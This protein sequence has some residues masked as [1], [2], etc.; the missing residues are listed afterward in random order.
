VVG[1]TSLLPESAL[2][3]VAERRQPLDRDPIL[4]AVGGALHP[5]QVAEGG[6]ANDEPDNRIVISLRPR[7]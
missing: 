3:L 1:R 7:W 4:R 5:D 6:D 2:E